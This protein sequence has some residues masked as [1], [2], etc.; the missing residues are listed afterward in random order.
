MPPWLPEP[1]YGDFLG[2]R[3]LEQDDIDLLNRWV[4]GGALEGEA[5]D[6]PPAPHW[7]DGWQIGRPDLIAEAPEAF[8]VPADGP[9]IFRNFVMPLPIAATRFVRGVEVRPGA[10]GAVHHATLLFDR[11]RASRRL[12]ESDP[13]PGFTGAM[14]S[15]STQNPDSHAI[16]WT[17]GTTPVLDSPEVSWRLLK[18]SDLVLQ[19]HMIPSGKPERVRPSVGFVFS[20]T[21]ATRISV[22]FKLGTKNIDIPAGE[23]RYA[24]EDRFE[25]PV[26]VSAFSIYPH[27]HYLGD[28]MKA[29][30]TLP[31]GTVRWL[32]WIKRWDFK[33]QDEY[34]YA[35]PVE[36]PKG[37]VLTMQ[38]SY[39]NSEA[40]PRNP[41]RPP[42]RVTFGPQS[43]DE[44]GDLWLRLFLRNADEAVTLANAYD[45]RELRK[46]VDYATMKVRRNP[47]D[48]A[49]HNLL[50]G[51]YLQS[52]RVD[53]AL[54]EFHETLRLDPNHPEAHYN[55]GQA[56]RTLGRSSEALAEFRTAARLAP[57]NDQV[58]V[59]LGNA[60]QDG[61]DVEEA[62]GY[63]RRALTLNPDFAG[64]HNNLGTALASQGRLEEAIA[65]FRR[66]LEDDPENR[67]ARQNLTLA[68]S[69]PGRRGR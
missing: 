28:E 63:Y 36:L 25:L 19:L 11:T 14:F 50:G 58:L 47:T 21:P 12:D 56:L 43:T 32:L 60:L 45:Q 15:D 67:D 65:E 61:G 20:D 17:P 48:P 41:T 2:Q 31:D 3:R 54:K 9:D 46:N 7:P 59:N 8:E 26:Q 66:A 30:A 40:N 42:R 37:A 39:N 24:V 68:E 38:Y 16:G 18:G 27:A 57:R 10:R 51:R 13:A 55:L 34:R 62:I 22:D 35:T 52:G 4:Q 5:T 44:M 23:A 64:A 69:L 6:L 49:S 1:G 29:F 33:W 53:E